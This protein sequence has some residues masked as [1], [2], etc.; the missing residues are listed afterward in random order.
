MSEIRSSGTSPAQICDFK[1]I[2]ATAPL[3]EHVKIMLTEVPVLRVEVSSGRRM[4]RIF[5]KMGQVVDRTYLDTLA[6]AVL[7]VVPNLQIV[8][9]EPVYNLIGASLEEICSLIW[10]KL[11]GEGWLTSAHYRITGD[12]IQVLLP[13]LL[14]VELCRS[15]GIH[16]L[17]SNRLL[18]DYGLKVAVDLTVEQELAEEFLRVREEIDQVYL[19]DVRAKNSGHEEKSLATGTVI[20]GS[21]INNEPVALASLQDEEKRVTIAGRVF[22][23]E[24]RELRSGRCLVSFEIT[25]ETDALTVKLF[26]EEKNRSIS[27]HLRNG[28][29]VKARGPLRYDRLTQELTMWLEDLSSIPEKVRRDDAEEK[30]VELHLHTKMSALDGLTGI[31]D[32]IRRAALWGHPAIAITDHGVVQAFPEAAE[33]GKKH[34]V[35][36]I[37][38]VEGYLLDDENAAGSQDTYH[39]V[40]LVKNQQGLENLYRLVTM[41]HLEHFYRRPRIPKSRL[42]CHRE[43]LLVGTACEA[44][45]LVR[46]YFK[47]LDDHHVAEIAGFYDYLEIQP[48]CNNEFMIRKGEVSSLEDLKKLNMSIV[49]LGLKLDKPVVATGDVHFLDPHDAIYRHILLAG[50]GMDDDTQTPLYYRTSKEMLAE[51]DYLGEETAKRVVIDNPR[52]LAESIEALKP[53]PDT[54]HPP[55]IPGAEEQIRQMAEE[56]AAIL[57]GE[58]LPAVVRERLDKELNA[59]ISH[60]FAVLYL[61]AHKLVRKSNEDGYL[62]G[63]R[64]SVG[65]SFV[66]TM[67]G[68]T[69]VNP[70]PPHYLC[71]QC[72]NSEF[73]LDGSCGSGADLTDQNCPRCQH[74]YQKEGHDIPF[75]VFLGFK[76]DKVPDIDLNFSGEYQP[77][78]HRYTEE[79]LGKE[80]VFRAGT[81]ATIAQRTAFGFVKNFMEGRGKVARSAE[82]NRL[83]AGCTGVKRTTGQHPG[84]LMVVPRGMDIHRFTPL[85]RPADDLDSQVITT[86]FDY[87]A[88]SSRLV[89]LDIL[90][91]DDPTV[92]K[93]LEDLTGAKAKDIPLDDPPTMA[94]FSGVDSLGVT[95]GDIGS[96]IGTYGIPEFGTRFVRQMLEDTRPNTF[97]DLVRICGFSHGTDVWLNNAQE[98]IKNGSAKMSEAI[99][100]RD[101]IMTYLILHGVLPDTAFKIMEGVRKGAGV[102]EEHEQLMLENGVPDWYIKSSKRIKYLF[103]KAH[104]VAYVMMAFRIAYFKVNYPE[105]FYTSYFSVRAAEFDA[106]LITGGAALVKEKIAEI[107]KKGNEATQK[108]KNLLS[109]LEVAVEMFARGIWIA[110]VDLLQSQATRFSLSPRLLLPPLTSLQGLGK[111]AAVNI[112]RAREERVFSSVEDLRTRAG[113]S[114]AVIEVLDR[115]G[116]LRDLPVTDQLT[117]FSVG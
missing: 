32:V 62:V 33:A 73:V 67:T 24:V 70:L 17:M 117:L 101:D 76:G 91:H 59:I 116:S 109:I 104:A 68:I 112:V 84:G 23:L 65:S 29:W 100:T 74:P 52:E 110:K 97:A 102:N 44:G 103:P 55:E 39:I 111:S 38:G 80:S 49:E 19:K 28:L 37:F 114:R 53:I 66:A 90:G 86:H 106:D 1:G 48:L 41:S 34:G 54:F 113:I 88:I 36:I 75:E 20:A 72:R 25:D 21:A 11:A 45:E 31:E 6:L 16:Q 15:K 64:G 5:L 89:K 26:E 63:S 87:H 35:K 13:N 30:R 85:Q 107:E 8:E 82:I 22:N 105:A 71:P 40:L 58:P 77:R 98:L 60:G 78:A 79:L 92:I 50:K 57:Y 108:E 27:G 81:I 46:G 93:M 12:K 42:R 115:H 95:P 9:I 4:W 47:G 10:G 94:I 99:S 83:V 2:I 7:K 51:F 18:H 43:G 61:I 14:A 96:L 56:Q 69:E 3:P